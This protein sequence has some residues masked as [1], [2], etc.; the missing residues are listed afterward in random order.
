M[1]SVG[2]AQSGARLA[3]DGVIKG[4][5]WLRGF[6]KQTEKMKIDSERIVSWP[7]GSDGE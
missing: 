3:V 2:Y 7:P 1:V 5:E 4:K 6:F